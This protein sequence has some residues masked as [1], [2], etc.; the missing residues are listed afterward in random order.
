MASACLRVTAAVM[1]LLAAY[2]LYMYFNNKKGAVAEHYDSDSSRMPE[3]LLS[4]ETNGEGDPAEAD[5]YIVTLY[6]GGISTPNVSL[7][8]VDAPV[9]VST[10]AVTDE[11]VQIKTPYH[12]TLRG[13]L[14]HRD[15]TL[16]PL[17]VGKGY[18]DPVEAFAYSGI[19]SKNELQSRVNIASRASP[20]QYLRLRAVERTIAAHDL[21]AVT[22]NGVPTVPEI[23][24]ATAAAG[25]AVT[26]EIDPV[27]ESSLS[28]LLMK[29]GDIVGISMRFSDDKLFICYEPILGVDTAIPEIVKRANKAMEESCVL[30]LDS[31]TNL[32]G[33]VVLTNARSGYRNVQVV[34]EF[35]KGEFRVCLK[36][37][38]HQGIDISNK[39]YWYKMAEML[40]HDE[41]R[42][43]DALSPPTVLVVQNNLEYT[44]VLPF[45]I[46]DL[47]VFW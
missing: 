18:A 31:G 17:P 12:V 1:L 20:C 32:P 35:V 21:A 40:S 41:I 4:T 9:E 26:Y 29:N 44:K 16:Q 13:A 39:A 30:A 10:S 46:G 24:K 37:Q 25:F 47:S 38:D 6:I 3:E 14:H 8:K 36:E 23:L 19:G 33:C 27:S 45:V 15:F 11:I 43:S 5:D 7:E 22:A 28:I 34:A 2:Y 42:Q